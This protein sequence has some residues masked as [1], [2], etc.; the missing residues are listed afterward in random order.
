[1]SPSELISRDPCTGEVIWRGPVVDAAGLDALVRR[2]RSA[3]ADWEDA[4]LERRREIALRFADLVRQDREG[5]A[6]LISR[7][8]GKPYWETLTEADSVAVVA[9]SIR[10]QDARAGDSIT[11]A[12]GLRAAIRHRP[13]GVL[14]VIGPFNFP[15]HLPNGHIV[16]ALLAGNAVVFKPSE[17]TLASGLRMAELWA[18]AGLP[19]GVFQTA[20]G[21]ADVGRALV[22]HDG[23]DGLLFTGGAAAGRSIHRAL[24]DR[25]DKILALELGGNNPLVAWDVEDAEAAA[26]LIVQSAYVSAGQR[27]SCARRLIVP[28]GAE[29]DRIV[30][31]LVALTDRLRVGAPFDEPQPFLG[32]V[33]DS[34]AADALLAAQDALERSGADAIRKMRRLT[35]A[36]PLLTP[37]LIDVTAVAAPPDEEYF[38]PMLQVRR[39]ETFEAALAAASATRFGLAAGLIGGDE[40]LWKTFW[41]GVRAGVVN[42]NRPTAGA[43]SAGPFGGIG[44]SGNHRPSAYYAADYCAWP[45]AGLEAPTPAFRIE[46]GLVAA[47]ES[48]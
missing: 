36:L 11:E 32:P 12:G 7:E 37:G 2:A 29:G 42:W 21:A 18:E 20:P 44:E 19:E 35:P 5:I 43:S 47:G 14:A 9:I 33:I 34:A 28:A 27:C 40:A 10:A 46:T 45:V 26:H 39:V 38:G 23:I 30:E 13:H 25:P 16:P 3:F 48:A 31:A 1:M 22:G 15:G 41:R 8:T 17:K 24:A 6:R 4:R